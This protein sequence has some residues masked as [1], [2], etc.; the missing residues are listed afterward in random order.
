MHLPEGEGLEVIRG[1]MVQD[2]HWGER[3]REGGRE[4]GG[5]RENLETQLLGL[6]IKIN[7]QNISQ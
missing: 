4:G 1:G 6:G 3:E 7:M 2:K 5:Q